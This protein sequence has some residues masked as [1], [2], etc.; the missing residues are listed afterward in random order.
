MKVTETGRKICETNEEFWEEISKVWDWEKNG[1]LKPTDL[2]RGIHKKIWVKCIEKEYHG[3]YEISCTNFRQGARCSYCS[4]N[5]GKVHSKDSFA[6]WGIDTIGKDFLSKYWD[7]KENKINPYKLAPQANKKI[8][9]KCRDTDYHGS[10][11]VVASKFYKGARC[12]YCMS[13][14]IHPRD[15]FAQYHTDNTDENFLEKYWDY[16]KNT[17]N[18]WEISP[19]SF[20]KVWIKCQEKEHHGSYEVNCSNF[21]KGSRCSYCYSMKVHP[22]DSFAWYHINNTDMNFIEKYWDYE[23]NSKL[24]IDPYKLSVS[25]NKRIWIKCQEKEYHES[26]EVQCDVFTKGHRCPYC[27]NRKVHP[28]DSLG[29]LYPEILEI[30]SSKNEVSPFKVSPHSGKHKIWWKCE[31]GKHEDYYRYVVAQT[32]GRQ[33]GFRCPEC[34]RERNE[35]FLQEKVKLYLKKLNY[36]VLHEN[37]CR[38]VPVNP[39]TK[40]ILPYDNEV[41][42]LKL[43]IEV[44]GVQHYKK[45][46]WNTRAA[47]KKKTTVSYELHKRKLYD[48]YKRMYAKSKGYHY[49]EIPY[50]TD[51]EEEEYKKLIDNKIREII[52]NIKKAI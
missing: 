44:H 1:D 24:G 37:R 3:S 5:S 38:I 21:K 13:R 16:E 36:V 12:P 29:S 25:C 40:N 51:N 33:S 7:Y 19:T 18:P 41:P 31:K 50:W 42:E 17:R 22:K 32:T 14:Q 23:K 20:K 48:R 47:K 4:L 45:S 39:K 26:Y 49:L 46:G 30:W 34:V 43:I 10:Y 28:K 52:E 6:Q 9:I 35:S 8:W 11:E 15:S 27:V 2:T